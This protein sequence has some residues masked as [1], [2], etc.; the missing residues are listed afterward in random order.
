MESKAPEGNTKIKSQRLLGNKHVQALKLVATSSAIRETPSSQNEKLGSK[1]KPFCF[2][3]NLPRTSED[4]E[5][6]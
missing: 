3:G 1:C 4:V 5:I 2:H 6:C